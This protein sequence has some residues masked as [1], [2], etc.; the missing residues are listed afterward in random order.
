MTWE[1]LAK[2]PYDDF[3]CDDNGVYASWRISSTTYGKGY[4]SYKDDEGN[5]IPVKPTDIVEAK[6]YYYRYP[7]GEVVE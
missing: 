1:Y 5:Y 3:T 6:D 4:V 2:Q 7:G